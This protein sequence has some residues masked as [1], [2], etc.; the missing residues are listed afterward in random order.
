MEK[1]ILAFLAI[2]LALAAPLALSTGDRIS[3]AEPN[4][5]GTQ[6]TAVTS[7]NLIQDTIEVNSPFQ[8]TVLSTTTPVLGSRKA[9]AGEMLATVT[10]S[11][12]NVGRLP[13]SPYFNARPVNAKAVVP[14]FSINFAADTGL[15]PNYAPVIKPGE[16][17]KITAEVAIGSY[18]RLTTLE[19]LTLDVIPG[20]PAIYPSQGKG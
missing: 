18:S 20:D 3:A 19:G 6:A 16:T 14:D 1:T 8:V 9:Y 15:P 2:V 17:V 5:T 11:I 10:I 13:H 4:P 12:K 7:I